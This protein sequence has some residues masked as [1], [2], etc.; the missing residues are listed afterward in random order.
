MSQK[1]IRYLAL[2]LACSILLISIFIWVANSKQEKI[3]VAGD[4]LVDGPITAT[5]TN[6]E[7]EGVH[8]PHVYYS[9]ES[10]A[11][12]TVMATIIFEALCR[13]STRFTTFINTLVPP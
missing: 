6:W 1:N 3:Q 7:Q 13:D 9:V 5:I 11:D 12:K 4:T 2:I 10:R 8:F